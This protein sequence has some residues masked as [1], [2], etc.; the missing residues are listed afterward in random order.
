MSFDFPSIITYQFAPN[1]QDHRLIPERSLMIIGGF[2]D[3]PW[4]VLLILHVVN[5][6]PTTVPLTRLSTKSHIH[7]LLFKLMAQ[8]N[9]HLLPIRN[10]KSPY[11]GFWRSEVQ[12]CRLQIT[13]VSQCVVCVLYFC[14]GL[15]SY[16]LVWVCFF[17]VSRGYTVYIFLYVSVS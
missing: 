14:H 2:N 12:V 6:I 13:I 4:E 17:T 10:Q 5:W 1:L 3:H 8:D 11:Q 15:G 9:H 7:H 16:L